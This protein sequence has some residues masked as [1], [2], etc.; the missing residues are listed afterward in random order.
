[1]QQ[2]WDAL[3]LQYRAQHHCVLRSGQ[4][5]ATDGVLSEFCQ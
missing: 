2:R 1:M 4:W 3:A 5:R